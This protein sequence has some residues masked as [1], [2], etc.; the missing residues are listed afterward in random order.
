MKFRKIVRADENV[1]LVL[2]S[3]ESCTGSDPEK[4]GYTDKYGN[5]FG[6]CSKTNDHAG[7]GRGK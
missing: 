7:C 5:N 4:S 6:Y 2:M 1:N 3:N